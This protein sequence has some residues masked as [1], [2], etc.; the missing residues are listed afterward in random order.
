MK[1]HFVRH[2]E[3]DWNAEGRLQGHSPSRLSEKGRREACTL[4]LR[5]PQGFKQWPVYASDL[6]RTVETADL[7]HDGH[8]HKLISSPLLR[9]ISL[10]RWEGKLRSEVQHTEP[11]LFR[12]FKQKASSWFR[13][14][15]RKST[16]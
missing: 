7:L 3:T 2:G 10:G 13:R 5:L 8:C 11:D 14:R 6:R 16:R 1:I 15:L 12:T 9:E 4:S